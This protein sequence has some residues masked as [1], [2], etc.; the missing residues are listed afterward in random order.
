VTAEQPTPQTD[1][2]SYTLY[3][4]PAHAG[5]FDQLRFS[6]PIGTML[7]E[8]QARVIAEFL[9]DVAGRSVLDVG[10]GTGRGAL[11]LARR[12]AR[13][14]GVDASTQMLDIARQRAGEE[15]LSIDFQVGDAHRLSFPDR[16]FDAAVS[17]RVLMHTPDWRRC[18]GELCRVARERVVFDYPAVLSAAALQAAA[19][20]VAAA[21][22][23]R[24]E[25]YRVFRARAMRAEL[26]R[27]GFRVAAEHRQFVLPI[28]LHKAIGS[29]AATARVEGLL[30]AVGLLRLLGSPVTV[31]ATREGER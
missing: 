15:K 8:T 23:A 16:S 28:A 25:A 10:T 24:T 9:P 2:Y 18:L 6:G 26:G 29:R 17:L 5:R 27:H 20:H 22:G 13:V 4:D 1:H 12:G 30:R 21:A 31:V 11:A 7:A 19:R 3:A 14:T